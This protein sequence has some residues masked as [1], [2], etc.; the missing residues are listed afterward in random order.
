MELEVFSNLDSV[1]S[2]TDIL[3]Q[4]YLI[5]DGFIF[6]SLGN[7]ANVYNAIVI[8]FPS[9]ARSTGAIFPSSERTIEEHIA[10]IDRHSIKKAIVIAEDIHFLKHCPSLEH[11]SIYPANSVNGEFDFSPLR[12]ISWLK[13]LFCNTSYGKE[14]S[15]KCIVD[16]SGIDN[17]ISLSVASSECINYNRIPSLKTLRASNQ[18]SQDL[19]GYFCSESLDSLQIMTSAIRSLDGIS[20][21]PNMQCVFL[22]GNRSLYD[23]GNLMD[24]K[25]SLRSLY[26][27]SCPRIKDFSVLSHLHQL[28][29]LHLSGSNVLQDVSFIDQL[30][31]LKTLILKMDV[32]SGD[33]TPCLKLSYVHVGKIRK[34]YNI[35]QKDLPK[36]K[37]FR[38]NENIEEWRRI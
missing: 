28:E 3:S 29:F 8:R 32:Q 27:D 22:Y 9:S 37:F 2:N 1:I 11:M 7:P 18:T 30:P 23:I 36:G 21:A 5:R 17:L 31:N 19:S 12:E 14:L 35:K 33:L 15:E 38:G 20:R 6:T 16:Y 25:D 10:F 24:V 26:I 4:K 13:S 34:H